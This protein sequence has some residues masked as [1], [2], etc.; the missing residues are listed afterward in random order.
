[1]PRFS[2]R[3]VGEMRV[4][5]LDKNPDIYTCNSYLILGE[6]NRLEDRNT[7]IDPGTD[8]SII[9]QIDRVPTGCGKRPVEQIILTHCHFDHAGGVP[10]LKRRYG[11]RVLAF[12]DGPEVD[13]LIC[14]GQCL[15]VADGHLDVI[16]TPEHSSDSISLFH[17]ESGSLFSGDTPLHIRG[18]EGSPSPES[19]LTLEKLAIRDIRLAYTG[20]SGAVCGALNEMVRECLCTL[21]RAGDRPEKQYQKAMPQCVCRGILQ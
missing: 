10:L 17:R 15:R 9:A 7:L 20:H 18:A 13:E 6:W 21:R 2:A 8:G 14:D 12:A 16:H 5:S 1:M 3:Q 11:A 4:K 19:L